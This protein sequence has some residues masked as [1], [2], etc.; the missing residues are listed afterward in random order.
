MIFLDE[1][2]I[3][4][5][6]GKGG[7]GVVRFRREKFIPFGGPNGGDGGKGGDVFIVSDKNLNTLV[8]FRGKKLFEAENGRPGEG[9][10]CNGID[11]EDLVIKVP[12]GTIIRNQI[13]GEVICDMKED[14]H[15]ICIARGGSGGFG[16]I[17]FKTST[18]Q[19]PRYAQKGKPGEE[20]EIHL[21][22]KLLADIALIGMPNAGK[23]TLISSLS[24]A[25]PKIADYPFTTLIPNLGVVTLGDNSWVV[26][27][28]PGL[29]E[30]ASEGKGL[31]TRF[32]KHIERTNAFVHLVDCSWCL[33]EY[34]A[35]ESYTTV[36]N[37]IIKYEKG[38]P[39]KKEIV[40]LTKC[41]ALSKEET[42]KFVT[43]FEKQ[44]GKKVLPLSAVSG[45]NLLKLKSLMH[46][47]IQKEATCPKLMLIMKSIPYSKKNHGLCNVKQPWPVPGY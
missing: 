22:L 23:S 24:K 25:R 34:E 38:L 32:L 37:E 47:C 15:K 19:A 5:A 21:E 18:N 3:T 40:C 30:N 27:D 6:A 9:W 1:V 39:E 13:S 46:T 12:I 44:L 26:A 8:K 16:N 41:D 43:F 33:D 31:G 17:N 2:K 4:V 28:I 10:D 20:Y 7:N 35:F 36:R 29:I 14:G 11:G 42:K 45:E